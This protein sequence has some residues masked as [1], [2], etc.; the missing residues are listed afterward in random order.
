MVKNV[1]PGRSSSPGEDGPVRATDG[2]TEQLIG[3]SEWFDEWV[4]DSPLSIVDVPLVTVGGGLGSLALVDYLRIAG[5]PPSSIAVLTNVDLPHETYRY[6]AANSQIPDGERLRSDAGSVM[7]NIWGFPSYA[8]R[9]AFTARGLVNRLKPVLQVATEPILS[10]YFTPRAG[11]VYESV[12]R[13][14]DR[15][16][17]ADMRVKG[18]VRMIRRRAN[19]GYFTVLTVTADGGTPRRVVYRSRFVHVS[20]GYPG[21]RFLPDLQQYREEHGNPGSVV[22]AYE[23]HDHVYRHLREAETTVVLRGSGIV[24]S[25]ILQ[26][27]LDD[28]ETHG[29]ATK[30]VH[31]F[32]NFVSEPQVTPYGRRPGDAGFAY[33]AFNYPKAAWGGQLREQ[34]LDASPDE[35][36]TILNATGGTNTAPRRAWRRQLDR[37]RASGVYRQLTGALLEMTPTED[38]GVTNV[39]RDPHGDIHR[40]TARYVIDCTGLIGDIRDSRVLADLVDQMGAGTNPLGRLDVAPTF[41]VSGTRSGDGRLYASGSI[42]LGG[43]YAPVDSFLGLQYAAQQICDDLAAEGFCRRIGPARSVRQWWRWVR[44]VGP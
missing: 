6:L 5:V 38:G 17:W 3:A 34:L 4:E 7:D 39:I 41:E 31:L 26:R 20:T 13:E 35:R 25:R 24:A 43:P 16:G 21:I 28:V 19:G 37:N 15:I 2:L 1:W 36:K 42:T 32:R 9:E 10:E 14:C 30:V 27:L 44:G 40:V 8:I 23:P 33:Q 22:N 29:A 11:Q 18:Q 12:E